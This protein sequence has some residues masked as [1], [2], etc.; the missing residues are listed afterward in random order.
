MALMAVWLPKT[1]SRCIKIYEHQGALNGMGVASEFGAGSN[2]NSDAMS[3]S[4]QSLAREWAAREDH[5]GN[6]PAAAVAV[7][8]VEQINR[9]IK[10][11][12]P[13]KCRVM[14]ALT[15]RL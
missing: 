8:M 11:Q 2:N 15:R 7:S 9:I 12:E 4:L 6:S 10:S 5:V 3:R 1:E 13:G 14:K